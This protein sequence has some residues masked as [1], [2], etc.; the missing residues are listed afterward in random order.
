MPPDDQ[1]EFDQLA[2]ERAVRSLS[3]QKIRRSPLSLDRVKSWVKQFATNEEKALAWLILRNL[4]YR[5]NEQLES[6]LRQALKAAAQ[7]FI[8]GT[9]LPA[10]AG[11][12][13]VLKGDY[14][15]LAFYCGPPSLDGPM[16]PGKS[17]ELIARLVGRI[18]NVQKYYPRD[19]VTF[20]PEERYLVV[21][22]GSYSGEQLTEFLVNWRDNYADNVAVVVAVAHE[23][24]VARLRERFPS[25]PLFY[26]ELLTQANSLASLS[27]EWVANGQWQYDNVSPRLLYKEICGRKG[28]FEGGTASE[29]F[30]SLGLSVAYEHGV[31][32][33]SLQLLWDRSATW[34]PLI[35]R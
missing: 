6:S 27:A 28:P 26:G 25:V 5:T 11:W 2:I 7:H 17:G 33:D 9:N 12:R 20:K 31:P 18:F 34:T 13:E 19:V 16:L 15:A 21:D 8:A 35:E 30:G 29:G 23:D 32:D 3:R 1:I 22:D 14:P 4:V 10:D 24:A